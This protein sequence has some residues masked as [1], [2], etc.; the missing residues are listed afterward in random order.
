MGCSAAEVREMT[1]ETL[2]QLTDASYVSKTCFRKERYTQLYANQYKHENA[3]IVCV[4]L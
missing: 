3:S 1:R 4:R 2:N